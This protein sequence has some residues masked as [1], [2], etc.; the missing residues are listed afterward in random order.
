MTTN[1]NTSNNENKR[2]NLNTQN[3]YANHISLII[4]LN[5]IK[6][7]LDFI[8]QLLSFLNLHCYNSDLNSFS[9]HLNDEILID[10]SINKSF[11][12]INEIKI[13][14]LN[15][16]KDVLVRNSKIRK[17]SSTLSQTLCHL[18]KKIVNGFCGNN[19]ILVLSTSNDE[20]SQ[21]VSLM[22]CIFAAQK[23][24]IVIDVCELFDSHT[25]FLQ[26][27]SNLTLGNYIKVN[28]Y[29]ALIQYLIVAFLPSQSLR[30]L[31]TLPTSDKVDF[32]ASCFCHNNIVDIAYICSVCLSIFC[33]P[34]S[35]CS[36][37]E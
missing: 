19:R 33:Q 36:T 18:N 17:L 4:D 23:H 6:F 11:I 3:N 21:Y 1:I 20:P 37:C 35:K 30:P 8:K 25:I 9:I 16:I 12:N 15:Y 13:S 32:R 7:N 27:A 24:R 28:H 31:L 2:E 5:N 22:N 26:Q 29:D 10:T 34:P 14:L